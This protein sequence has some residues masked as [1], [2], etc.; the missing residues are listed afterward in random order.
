MVYFEITDVTGCESHTINDWQRL[1][2]DM[3]AV[4]MALISS[5]KRTQP[6]LMGI[7]KQAAVYIFKYSELLHSITQQTITAYN[8]LITY[9]SQL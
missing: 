5:T 8:K 4:F 1:L 2:L 7:L 6:L 9:T 3:I